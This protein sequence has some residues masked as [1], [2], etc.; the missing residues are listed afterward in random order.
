MLEFNRGTCNQCITKLGKCP[1][2]PVSS[3]PVLQQVE[4]LEQCPVCLQ[5]APVGLKNPRCNHYLC[6]S[7][8][9]AI[10][11]YEDT[12]FIDTRP[13]FPHS[14]QE[15]DYLLE[16][17]LFINDERVMEWK[18]QLGSWNERRLAFVLQNKKYLKH[19]PVCRQ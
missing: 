1:E 2:N 7:C 11:W 4:G 10:Y 13:T 3:N 9:K 14:E 5:S 19:C 6:V 8:L 16:P 17:Q 18:K 15:E 12:L